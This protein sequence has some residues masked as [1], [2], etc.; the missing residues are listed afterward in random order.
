MCIDAIGFVA[1]YDSVGY[2]EDAFTKFSPKGNVTGKISG[3]T[4]TNGSSGVKGEARVKHETDRG[5]KFTGEVSGEVVRGSDGKLSGKAE[6]KAGW[7]MEYSIF[8]M[9]V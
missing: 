4:D 2:E 6:V 9:R 3:S 7:E 1:A 5:G 8:C